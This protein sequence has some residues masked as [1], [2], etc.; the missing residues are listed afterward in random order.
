VVED[1]RNRIIWTSKS[2]L[3]VLNSSLNEWDPDEMD[4]APENSVAGLGCY[5]DML[6]REP[7]DF[8]GLNRV[9]AWVRAKVGRL[10]QITV[11]CCRADL[12]IR[13][14]VI[15]DVDGFGV[16]AYLSACGADRRAAEETLG[17]ALAV[18]TQAI[19]EPT[20]RTVRP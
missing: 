12:V 20:G 1:G 14:A 16:T 11:R 3:W 10:R 6:P 19:N 13:R 15:G 2:D 5:I 18:L 7:D 8:S 4:A 17:F 9:E